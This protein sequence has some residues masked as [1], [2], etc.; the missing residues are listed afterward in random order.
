[1]RGGHESI[2]AATAFHELAEL[3]VANLPTTALAAS[4]QRVYRSETNAHIL[5][6][7]SPMRALTLAQ[8]SPAKI[9]AAL[10][11]VAEAS[12]YGAGKTLLTVYHSVF[13][14]AL[15]HEANSQN[16]PGGAWHEDCA[17]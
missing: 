9:N 1:M 2:T 13:E 4:S 7:G 16:P 15:S 6:K 5:A 14:L 12:G 3:W 17:E 10:R 11:Q 8:I